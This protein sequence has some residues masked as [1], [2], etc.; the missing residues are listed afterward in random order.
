MARSER[1]PATRSR[2]GAGDAAS[3][4]ATLGPSVGDPVEGSIRLGVHAMST[5]ATAIARFGT[6]RGTGRYYGSVVS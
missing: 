3:V 6:L 1:Q 5:T 2:V 4:G